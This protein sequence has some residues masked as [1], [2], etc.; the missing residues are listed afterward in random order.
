MPS[1]KPIR[2][3]GVSPGAVLRQETRL[4]PTDLRRAI[5]E[6]VEFAHR[7]ERHLRVVGAGLHRDV[8]AGAR[9]LQL[10]A[11]EFRQVDERLRPPGGEAVAVDAVLA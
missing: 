8:A 9:G 1:L 3:R 6:A 2:L 11:V 4:R 10:V 7:V 5:G